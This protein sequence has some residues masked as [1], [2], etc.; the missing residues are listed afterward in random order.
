MNRDSTVV[1]VAIFL[2][3]IAIIGIAILKQQNKNIETITTE[4]QQHITPILEGEEGNQTNKEINTEIENTNTSGSTETDTGTKTH[5]NTHLPPAENINSSYTKV[6]KQ[7]FAAIATKDYLSACAIIAWGKCNASRPSSVENFSRE[8]QKMPNGYEY[9]NIK[10]YGFIAP[11]GKHVVCVKYSYRYK[12]DPRPWLVS[13]V[14]SFYIDKVWWDLKITDRV[15]EKKYK[16]G[17]GLR[18]CPIKANK[19]FCVGLVK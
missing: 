12:N 17:R 2:I 8:F 18:D 11:S 7:Y 16:D 13:E 15:C 14:M 1:Q 10:D 6:V 19:N 3:I 4:T 9:V 5:I